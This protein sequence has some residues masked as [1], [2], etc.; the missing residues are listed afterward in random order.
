MTFSDSL[1]DHAGSANA[2]ILNI[3]KV[4][5]MDEEGKCL[6][7]EKGYQLMLIPT[8]LITQYA[9]YLW[10]RLEL[11]YSCYSFSIY[12]PFIWPQ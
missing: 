6:R 12:P 10:R 1:P 8:Y 2:D 11:D 7:K 9:S 5:E 3:K 4:C